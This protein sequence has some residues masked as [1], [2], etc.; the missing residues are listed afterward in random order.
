MRE[1][2]QMLLEAVAFLVADSLLLSED[3]HPSLFLQSVEDARSRKERIAVARAVVLRFSKD[4]R[5]SVT[6]FFGSDDALTLSDAADGAIMTI[7]P[8]TTGCRVVSCVDV[9]NVGD[10]HGICWLNV[11]LLC[12]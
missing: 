3:R 11:I 6:E 2:N 5:D 9:I 12:F 1:A 4:G 8:D 7:L 10:V